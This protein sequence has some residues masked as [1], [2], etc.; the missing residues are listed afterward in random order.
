M[1]LPT[2]FFFWLCS[3]DWL[4]DHPNVIGLSSYVYQ[5]PLHVLID[6]PI[7]IV[8]KKRSFVRCF[9]ESCHPSS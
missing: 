6:F 3:F 5:Y 7:E 9:G 2:F 8:I 4:F 1:V